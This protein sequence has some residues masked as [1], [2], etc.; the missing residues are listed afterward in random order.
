MWLRFDLEPLVQGQTRGP[1]GVP[2]S[3]LLLVLEVWDV[4]T[5]YRKTCAGNLLLWSDLTLDP[6]FKVKLLWPNLKG[7]ISRLLLV[8]EVW[9]VKT[10]YRKTCWESFD[11]VRFDLEPL[12]QGQMTMPKLKSAYISL[13]SGLT[14]GQTRMAK[15]KSAYI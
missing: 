3:C 5:T 13:I 6:S 7:P 15:L 1:S 4:K 2:I 11:V 14:I 9:D 8:L 12:V 10:T